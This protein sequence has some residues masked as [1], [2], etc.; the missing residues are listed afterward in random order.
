LRQN[1]FGDWIDGVDTAL[2]EA[3]SAGPERA[4][5]SDRSINECRSSARRRSSSS[6]SGPERSTRRVNRRSATRGEP[7]PPFKEIN[8]LP[9]APMRDTPYSGEKHPHRHELTSRSPA[10]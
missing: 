10:P 1:G 6:A 9:F 8:C 3:L 7:P 4:W 5:K 2:D